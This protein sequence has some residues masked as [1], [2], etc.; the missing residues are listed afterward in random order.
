MSTSKS[1][2]RTPLGRVRNLGSA[3]AGTT[4]FWRQRLTAVAMILLIIPVIV[5]VIMML[6][7]HAAATQILGSPVVAIF[8]IMFII[9]SVWHMKI[10][11]QVVIEDYVIDEKLKL[12]AIIGN[13]F[14]SM[15]VALAA[16]YAILKKSLGV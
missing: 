8:L 4:D 2:M 9:A 12:V 13:N 7:S 15:A 10:G 3:R 1:S 14:F 5:I 11:M 6:G 16:I